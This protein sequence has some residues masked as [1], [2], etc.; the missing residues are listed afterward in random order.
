MAR[1]SKR[2]TQGGGFMSGEL[3]V[4]KSLHTQFAKTILKPFHNAVKEFGLIN[5]G[6]KIAVCVSGG[7]DSMLL[8][9]LVQD[10]QKHGSISFDVVFLAMNPGYSAENA[11]LL[12]NN[13]QLIGIPLT[14]FD[15]EVFHRLEHK[16]KNP[17]FLCA[18]LRRTQL[19]KHAQ[20][21]GCN[22][23]ALGHHFDD[24]IETTLMAMLYGGQMQTMLPRRK[25][26]SFAEMELIRPL[27]YVREKDIINWSTA[28]GLSFL[29]C[30]CRIT[31][32]QSESKRAE[33]KALIGQLKK[34]NPQIEKNIFR[35]AQNVST[36][37]LFSYKDKF[38]L[39][40]FLDD[41]TEDVR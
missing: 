14:V 18:T 17:C 11:A 5:D 9:K 33:I 12:L 40:S 24:V 41:F 27:Y 1:Y 36:K 8:A 22:K 39:H 34:I 37:N 29:N 10:Y 6:D 4:E 30:A 19:Y 38:G 25:S 13:A 15:T 26:D 3:S 2:I 28:N 20:S 7:K 21:L 23:I 31:Q 32:K 16:K 35:S